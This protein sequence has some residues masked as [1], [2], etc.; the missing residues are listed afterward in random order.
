MKTLSKTE[1]REIYE[2]LITFLDENLYKRQI[3]IFPKGLCFLIADELIKVKPELHEKFKVG[4]TTYRSFFLAK[5]DFEEEMRGENALP[6]IELFLTKTDGVR[7]KGS[8]LKDDTAR[9]IAL[10][11]AI[12]ILKDAKT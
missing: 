7:A 11:F 12:E 2:R 4:K 9:I 6:E 5:Y 10:T 3:E 8:F 1:R